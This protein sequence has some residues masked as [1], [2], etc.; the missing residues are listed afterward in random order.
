[1][2]ACLAGVSSDIYAPSLPSISEDLHTPIDDVQ[3]SMAIFMLGIS[4]SQLI[5][6]PLSEGLGR[7]LPLLIGL[8]INILGSII[9]FMTPSITM[10]ILGRFIQGLGAGAGASLWRSIFRDCFTGDLLAKYGSYLSI[11]IIFIVPAAPT[12]GGYLQTYFGWR[13]NFLF[14][15]GYSVATIAIVAFLFKETSSHHHKD[16]LSYTFF[17]QS[18]GTLLLSP[19]FMGYTMCTF[20]SYGA[21]FSWFVAGPVLLIEVIGISPVEFGWITF[22]VGGGAMATA[23]I[24]NGKLVTNLGATFMLRIGW[25]IMILAGTIML[26]LKLLYGINIFIIVAPMI[27]F[28]FGATLI[29]PSV[30]SGAFAPFGKIAG[31]TGA[32]Y[33]FM[34]IGGAAIIG[35]LVTFLPDTDQ[36]PLSI[37]FICAPALAWIVFEVVVMKAGAAS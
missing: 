18:F 23:S 4:I 30:F 6:G 27:L 26:G 36:V 29:W 5:Y 35:G 7:K 33:S 2:V 22:F 3:L 8:A 15:L 21:F 14:L 13:A 19:I 9:C 11:G 1:L 25:S 31:Y 37:L 12:L 10:L 32:L 34:Q 17:K 16:R 20:L 24:V 28:Y